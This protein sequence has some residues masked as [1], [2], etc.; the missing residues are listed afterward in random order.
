MVE[1]LIHKYIYIYIWVAFIRKCDVQ[2]YDN[3]NNNNNS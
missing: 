3:N 1:N 2:L